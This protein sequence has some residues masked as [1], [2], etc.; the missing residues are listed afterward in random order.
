MKYFVLLVLVVLSFS[1][2]ASGKTDKIDSRVSPKN[3]KKISED[4]S[5]FLMECIEVA[6]RLNPSLANRLRELS[7]KNPAE[8]SKELRSKGNRFVE[9]VRLKKKDIDLYNLKIQQLVYEQMIQNEA[10]NLRSKKERDLK[11]NSKPLWELVMAWE[12]QHIAINTHLRNTLRKR[13]AKL[14][15]E[16]EKKSLNL[17]QRVEKITKELLSSDY[18]P[19]EVLRRFRMMSIRPHKVK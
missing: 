14:D 8:L 4:I 19:I 13:L 7:L 1:G 11:V 16:I 15:N 18:P 3:V 2:F 12:A 5:V 9:L 10:A 6:D 17:Q